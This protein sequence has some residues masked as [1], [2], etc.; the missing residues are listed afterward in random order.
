MIKTI[1]GKEFRRMQLLQMDMLDELDRVCRVNDINYVMFAG[2]LLG[3][4]RHKGYIPWDDDA[5]IGMLREDYERFKKV[6]SQL[7]PDVCFFQDHTTDPYYRWGYGKLRRTG[8]VFIREGQE[9]IKCKTGVFIDIFPLDDI[10]QSTV[11][12]MLQDFVC[13]CLRKITWSEV[14]KVSKHGLPKLWWILLSKIPISW[15]YNRLK[16]Y[17]NKSRNDS[18]NYV[19]VLMFP[20][21]GKYYRKAP[22]KLRYG[23]PKKWITER[24][25]Y[26][27]EG[28]FLYGTKDYDGILSTIYGDYMKLPPENERNPHAPVSYYS[29]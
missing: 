14:A 6:S 17:E 19:R 9:H 2:T 15:V 5:D 1:D 21:L 4:V 22:L 25:E 27:F 24:A 20:S 26:E 12:Q 3:A 10:P 8:T 16:H 7:N 11:G 13:F 29:F 18:E 23:F 28:R